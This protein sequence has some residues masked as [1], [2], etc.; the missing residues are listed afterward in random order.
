MKNDR[1]HRMING[2]PADDP[3]VERPAG[4]RPLEHETARSGRRPTSSRTHRR[5]G[6]PALARRK[7]GGGG[8]ACR[9]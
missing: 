7:G 1:L 2:L 5:T 9:A 3:L 6:G 8:A 4:Q